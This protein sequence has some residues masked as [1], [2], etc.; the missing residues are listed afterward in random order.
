MR[1]ITIA[2]VIVTFTFSAVTVILAT[3]TSTRSIQDVRIGDGRLIPNGIVIP[4]RLV[5]RSAPEYTDEARQRHIEGSVR[6]QAEFDIQGNFRVIRILKGLGFGLD[7]KALIALS[8]WRFIPAYK[9]GARVSVIAE[10]DVPFRLDSDL[11]LRAIREFRRNGFEDGRLLLQRLINTYEG[12]DYL[13]MAKYQLGESFYEEGTPSALNQAAEEFRQFLAFFPSSPLSGS[14]KQQLE[15][16][17]QILGTI[18]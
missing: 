5:S 2:C 14:A 15:R 7:E 12:S 4:P 1:P 16:V 3:V 17:Q 10:I 13:P 8:N 18:K 6:V 9:N 11:Y